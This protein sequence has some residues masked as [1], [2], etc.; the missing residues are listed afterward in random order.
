MEAYLLPLRFFATAFPLDFGRGLVNR[1][2]RSTRLPTPRPSRALCVG[3][4]VAPLIRFSGRDVSAAGVGFL[5]GFESSVVADFVSAFESDLAVVVVSAFVSVLSEALA[6][7]FDGVAAVH[8][9]KV[10]D[11]NGLTVYVILK[12]KEAKATALQL[13]RTIRFK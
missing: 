11:K 13:F 6:S 4:L 3:V 2:A 8:F 9:P 10:K 1:F 12:K 7:V 5:A